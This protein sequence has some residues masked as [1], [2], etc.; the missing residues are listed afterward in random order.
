MAYEDLAPNYKVNIGG[1]D[2]SEKLRPY[3]ESLS[4]DLALGMADAL[5]VTLNNPIMTRDDGTVGPLWSD[6][7]LLK[8]GQLV[9]VWIGYGNLL[10]YA[11]GYY[12]Q[13]H[14]PNFPESGE[15]THEFEAL[16]FSFRL[17]GDNDKGVRYPNLADSEI[18]AQVVNNGGYP[19]SLD[20]DQ[21]SGK[22][23]RI[24]KQGMSDYDFIKE[25]A[26][27]NGFNFWVDH[28]K[29]GGDTLHFK[30]RDPESLTPVYN[31]KYL[32]GGN[33]TLLS[34]SPDRSSVDQS[35][36]LEVVW[37]NTKEKRLM[38]Q[39]VTAADVFPKKKKARGKKDRGPEA[40]QGISSTFG[41]LPTD[42]IDEE[43]ASG[44]EV[45]VQAFGANLKIISDRP[46]KSEEDVKKFAEE[47]FKEEGRTYII[48]TGRLVG[49]ELLRPGQVHEFSG[50][51]SQLSGG[52][53][54]ERVTHNLTSGGGYDCEVS[55]FKL[56]SS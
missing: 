23:T 56:A 22:K 37:Y 5:K 2:V 51:G 1:T 28:Q 34:F 7:T 50:I 25:L 55:V 39:R 16:D 31:F 8:E 30:K 6:S 14:T 42:V 32:T 4:I 24:Q 33:G 20:I 21:T 44:S 29:G 3:V 18:V 52:Y 40:E 36:A 35:L 54:F 46:F 26:R 48:G 17:M 27:I 15:P 13:A 9:E 10:E 45:R 12:I 47:W 11:G 53:Y 38:R 19:L 49:T 41:G 43:I